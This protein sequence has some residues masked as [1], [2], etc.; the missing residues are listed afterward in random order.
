MKRGP[1]PKSKD[2]L[3]PRIS[4]TLPPEIEK[5]RQTLEEP[6]KFI[7]KAIKATPKCK[8]FLKDNHDNL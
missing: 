4:L 6:T 1:K 5:F 2:K 8:K 3:Y 7:V